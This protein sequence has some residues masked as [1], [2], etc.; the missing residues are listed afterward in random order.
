MPAAARLAERLR[1]S[2]PP[3]GRHVRVRPLHRTRAEPPALPAGQPRARD[4]LADADRV[5]AR[6]RLP[7]DAALGGRQAAGAL[8]PPARR[9]RGGGSAAAHRDL[10]RRRRRR[11]AQLRA[12]VRLRARAGRV[13]LLQRG[14]REG[15]GGVGRHRPH[16]PARQQHAPG[17]RRSQVLRAHQA[18]RGGKRIRGTLVG[19]ERWAD[20]AGGCVRAGL[21]DIRLLARLAEGRH[22][23][24]PP[25]ALVP[26]AQR[27]HAQGPEL[28]AHRGDPRGRHHVA[29][30]DA[31]RRAQLGLPVHLDTRLGVHASR[32]LRA[33]LRVGGVR[34]PRIHARG[35]R[36]GAAPDHVRDR[37]RAGAA[38]AN[39]RPPVRL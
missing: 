7:R 4:H 32:P 2:A 23:P 18:E 16:G 8:P 38:R 5:A 11:R 28:R 17:P 24:R 12:A 34:V 33:R 29:P 25:V 9:L 27:A 19:R 1:R 15:P 20:D 6:P 31:W 22:L 36:R 21:D 13:Q 39:A 30:R 26:R 35:R 10:H 37:W 3:S 14:L